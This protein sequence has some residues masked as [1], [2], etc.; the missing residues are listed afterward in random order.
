MVHTSTGIE[1]GAASGAVTQLNIHPSFIELLS[2][3]A[4]IQIK[5]ATIIALT[6][7]FTEED[8]ESIQKA[9]LAVTKGRIDIPHFAFT[10]QPSPEYDESI[11]LNPAGARMVYRS[12]DADIVSIL[13]T[14]VNLGPAELVT[15]KALFRLEKTDLPTTAAPSGLK[16]FKVESRGEGSIVLNFPRFSGTKYTPID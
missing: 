9:F 5:T 2:R 3:L 10:L 15:E 1:F 16:H 14:S 6:R 8:L 4:T 13:D 7:D 12:N 11:L